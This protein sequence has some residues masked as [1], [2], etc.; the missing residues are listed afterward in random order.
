[1]IT[2]EAIDLVKRF[3]GCKLKSYKCSA[4]VD[5]IGYGSTFYEDGSKVKPGDTITQERADKLLNL[6]LNDFLKGILK[7]VKV[8]LNDNQTG[9]ILSFVYNVGLGNFNKSTLLKK[10][11]VNPNDITIKAEF[12][13][14]NKA[15][16]KELTGLTNRRKAEA[17]MYYK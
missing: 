10:L 4:G 7:V 2:K 3:E 8:K 15:L 17:E 13:K 14:W 1:M 11:N 9:A 16:G 6:V 5:T 12:M